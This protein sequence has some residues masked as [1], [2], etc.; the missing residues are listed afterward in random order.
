MRI[1]LAALRARLDAGATPYFRALADGGLSRAAFVDSQVQFFTAV[2][3]FNRPM[4]LLASRMPRLEER[5]SLVE[6][7]FDE[8]GRGDLARSHER[9]FLDL[10]ARLDVPEHDVRA[11]P[12]GPEVRAFNAML[13]G[14]CGAGDP[15][16]AIATLGMIEDLFAV[17]SAAIGRGIVARGWLGLDEVV[18]YSTH[19][20]L[21]VKHCE[22]FHRIVEP[23]WPSR[24]DAIA[25]GYELGGRSFLQ[26]YDGLY[27]RH[28]GPA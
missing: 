6:N 14:V 18:H 11:R 2:A 12:V 5:L 17:L 3:H 26:L 8:H 22:A 19:E 1:F 23:H 25:A 15:Y 24:R 28:H 21:D 27:A 10:L 4:M 7:V 13:D 16:T 9:T 20:V